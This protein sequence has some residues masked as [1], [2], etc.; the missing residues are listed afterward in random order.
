MGCPDPKHA[1]ACGHHP[2]W[3]YMVCADMQHAH[4]A[5]KTPECMRTEVS[6]ADGHT[7]ILKAWV[8][9]IVKCA[10]NGRQDPR[11]P[12]IEGNWKRL[13]KEIGG[14]M[15]PHMSKIILG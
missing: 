8:G 13:D 14:V 11:T 10:Q 1:S 3:I 2:L 9:A 12:N 4:Q 15:L 5:G 6:R 7:N